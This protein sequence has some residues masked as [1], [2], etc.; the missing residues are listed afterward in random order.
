MKFEKKWLSDS[1]V[2]EV[3][4][5]EAHSYHKYY[6]TQE[7]Y[8]VKESSYIH[9]LNGQWKFHYAANMDG[10]IEGFEA[11]D[12]S[13]MNWDNITVPAH[14]QMEGYDIPQ[15]VNVMY[16]WD[17]HEAIRPGAI[18]TKFN[19]V[20]S[21]VKYITIP[22]HMKNMP[23]YISFQGV[24]SAFSIWMNG[25]FVG[26]SED[27]FTPADFDLSSYLVDG[28]NKLAVQVYK[29]TSASWLEDQDFYRFSGIFR[30]VYLYTLPELHVRD[31][32]VKTNLTTDY[33]DA[34]LEIT[35]DFSKLHSKVSKENKEETRIPSGKV[36]GTLYKILKDDH[37]V[38][39]GTM[40][41]LD[42]VHSF[43]YNL[44][45]STSSDNKLVIREDVTNPDLWSAES[46]NLYMIKLDIITENNT[47]SEII[48]ERIGFRS[49]ELSDGLMKINGKRIVFKGTNRHEF[50][51]IFG[52]AI[53]KE[54]MIKDVIIMKQNN[55]NAVRTSHYPNHPY[56]YELCDEYGLYVIDEANLETH[57]TWQMAEGPTVHT[58]PNDKEEWLG[59][60]LDRVNS[61]VQRDK[62]HP[63][64]IIWSCGNEAYGGK[65]IFL[66]SEL[67][68]SLDNSRLVHYEGIR[69]DRRY[70]DTSDMESQMYTKVVDIQHFLEEYP[71]KPFI[72][73]EYT[74]A[75]GNSCGGMH[76]YTDLTDTH[77]RYQGGFIWDFIDQTILTKDRYGN[78]FFAYGGDIGD[79]PCDY[80]FCTNGIVYSDRRVSPKMQEVKFNYQNIQVFPSHTR[81]HIKNKNLF[82]NL[83]YY[84]GLVTVLRDGLVI[85][86]KGFVA[87]I[88]P[89]AEQIINLP[90][91]EYKDKA[92]EYT[93]LVSFHLKKDE[94]W[95]NSGHEVAFGQFIYQ[96]EEKEVSN[97]ISN[98]YFEIIDCIANVGVKGD[99][100]HAIFD[101]G[102]K[103][104]V[105]YKYGGLDLFTEA[106]K[107]N[108]WRAPIDN[109]NGNGMS[110]RY[111][112]WK[113]ASMYQKVTNTRYETSEDSFK[114]YY[115][116]TMP[117][118]IES[119]CILSY[120]VNKEGS[121][122][123]ELDYDMVEGLTDMPEFGL[124]M[125][126]AADYDNVTWYGHGPEETYSDRNKGAKLGIYNN[127]VMDNLSGYV[128]PQECGNKTGVRYA[129]VTNRKQQGLLIKASKVPMEFS[130]LPYTP[131]E[132]ENAKHIYELPQVHHTVLKTSLMQM[133]VGGDDSWGA[134]THDEYLVKNQSMHFEITFVGVK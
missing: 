3:N 88:P 102:G 65:N 111:A 41:T 83:N 22:E 76:K 106:P 134:P 24:E 124:I 59:A 127:K 68:R 14:I 125:K 104:L 84:Q 34:E 113:L 60:V 63:S 70:N 31:M 103:G 40:E 33:R 87:H 5:I 110:Y 85:E 75:M 16:P 21:Y 17:G 96:V 108:F 107:A 58:V 7:E 15:Y 77:P 11:S 35:L 12:Y 126:M 114:I 27:T 129:K 62:N 74:H 92:G 78:E 82:T 6:R 43:E 56:F 66:M 61:L 36:V 47:I 109:D 53:K 79:K 89:L 50:S 67:F 9:S 101:K 97:T 99:N 71:E 38:G 2:Y 37:I 28:V 112:S 120:T 116:Y 20:A 23:L 132:L 131:H 118:Y 57:G 69:H 10:A 44:N 64:V 117:T 4:R 19:P 39:H 55:I 48:T 42:E 18:P 130:A 13:C 94:Q 121:I 25:T 105:M 93:V 32:F 128:N 49:F 72:C 100:F 123:V 30:D 133:G 91:K 90:I 51:A 81:V 119:K 52:R 95:A 45:E 86:K 122:K 29:W 98:G 8:E 46:P 54:D 1:R 115:T 73:C 26:Y 80:N